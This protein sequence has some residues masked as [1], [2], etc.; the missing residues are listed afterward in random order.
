[1]SLVACFSLRFAAPLG[2][3]GA[4][5]AAGSRIVAAKVLATT[6]IKAPAGARI[7]FA[8]AGAGGLRVGPKN[9]LVAVEPRF[10]VVTVTVTPRRGKV[11]RTTI[12]VVVR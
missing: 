2:A 7:R 5:L 12:T 11:S 4:L 6:G 3:A 10:Y 1:M 9:S 8:I